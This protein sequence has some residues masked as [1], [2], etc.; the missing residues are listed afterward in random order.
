VF[1]SNFEFFKGIT[2]VITPPE[3]NEVS[4]VTSA[5]NTTTSTDDDPFGQAPFSLPPALRE[6]GSIK[7]TGG[8]A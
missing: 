2:K 5:T 4:N 6:R 3:Q 7:K 8:K 1:K